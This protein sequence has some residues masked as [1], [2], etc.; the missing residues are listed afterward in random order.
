MAASTSAGPVDRGRRLPELE[1][2]GRINY[3]TPY[4]A[5]FSAVCCVSDSVWRQTVSVLDSSRTRSAALTGGA[6][7]RSTRDADAI[8][9]AINRAIALTRGHS[10]VPAVLDDDATVSIPDMAGVLE[11]GGRR[12]DGGARNP[13]GMG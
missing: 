2:D 1:S 4:A 5:V 13:Q 10:Q 12:R 6:T 7:A 9:F 3:P 11:E 8:V